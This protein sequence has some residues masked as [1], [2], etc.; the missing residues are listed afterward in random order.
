MFVSSFHIDFP[1]C[2]IVKIKKS[3][4]W[5]TKLVFFLNITTL[6]RNNALG[7]NCCFDERLSPGRSK[8]YVTFDITE[9]SCT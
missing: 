1:K 3:L 6:L 9:E 5:P 7:D 8:P 2:L 4:L